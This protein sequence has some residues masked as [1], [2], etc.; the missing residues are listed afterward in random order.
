MPFLDSLLDPHPEDPAIINGV[1]ISIMKTTITFLFNSIRPKHR[2]PLRQLDSAFLHQELKELVS[3][4][5]IKVI[6]ALG[7]LYPRLVHSQRLFAPHN[8]SHGHFLIIIKFLHLISLFEQLVV[9]IS[10]VMLLGKS[11]ILLETVSLIAH[12]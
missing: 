8:L 5:D 9:D 2:V 12:Q 10:Y 3:L 4:G 11:G 7:L 1:R 6:R